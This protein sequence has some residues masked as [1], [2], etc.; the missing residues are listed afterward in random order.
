MWGVFISWAS[1]VISSPGAAT[2][3][4]QTVESLREISET[5]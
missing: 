5:V 2:T 4:N 1:S 3:T